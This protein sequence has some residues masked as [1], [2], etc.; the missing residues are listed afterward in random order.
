M[1]VATYLAC[2]PGIR[3]ETG[4]ALRGWARFAYVQ[5]ED[6][7]P[8]P[9]YLASLVGEDGVSILPDDLGAAI[10]GE[11]DADMAI[12]AAKIAELEAASVASGEAHA[13]EIQALKAANWDALQTSAAGSA[14]D[15]SDSTASSDPENSE[16]DSD[17]GPDI[18]SFFGDAN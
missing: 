4:P 8:L 2:S 5:K 17:E 9:D 3:I 14:D 1:G 12:P 18:D 16:N 11:Y 6:E 15:T 13:A 10:I 7:M